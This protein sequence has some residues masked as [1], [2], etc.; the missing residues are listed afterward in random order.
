MHEAVSVTHIGVV[1]AIADGERQ[2]ILSFVAFVEMHEVISYHTDHII[3]LFFAA[4]TDYHYKF[5]A[6]IELLIC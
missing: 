6:G 5:V 4:G 2:C 3:D 1:D